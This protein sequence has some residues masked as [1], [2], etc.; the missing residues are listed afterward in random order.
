MGQKAADSKDGWRGF[1][2]VFVIIVGLNALPYFLTRG[3]Y[4]GDGYEIVGFPFIFHEYGGF[5]GTTEFCWLALLADIFIGLLSSLSGGFLLGRFLSLF[6]LVSGTIASALTII[7]L[8]Y[9]F[10]IISSSQDPSLPAIA[11]PLFLICLLAALAKANHIIGPF[12]IAGIA[13][14]SAICIRVNFAR[15]SRFFMSDWQQ[16]LVIFLFT[17][18]FYIL[19]WCF[20]CLMLWVGK[21]IKNT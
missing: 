17:I 2:I 11:V 14:S 4:A 9:L 8:K 19:S 6:Q 1:S 7:Y 13:V 3:S 21:G 5:G 12:I 18:F 16:I 10:V 15:N 20:N